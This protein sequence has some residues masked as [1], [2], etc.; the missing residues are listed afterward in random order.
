MKQTG[1]HQETRVKKRL[2]G[3][4][5]WSSSHDSA[6]TEGQGV[7]VRRLVRESRSHMWCG[8]AKKKRD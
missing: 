5:W 8:V 1:S 3:L 2:E 6:F 7:H 4:P